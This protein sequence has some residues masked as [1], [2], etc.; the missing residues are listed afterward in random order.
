MPS[1][2]VPL[3]SAAWL[4]AH[5]DDSHVRILEVDY[6]PQGTYN[7]AHLPGALLV[8]WR[9]DLNHPVIRDVLTKE[10]LERLLGAAGVRPG[11]TL[12]VYGDLNNWFGAFAYWTVRYYGFEDVRLLDGGRRGWS[13]AAGPWTRDVPEFPPTMCRVSS[14]DARVRAF[15]PDVQ[16]ARMRRETVL[17]DVR[18]PAEFTGELVAPPEFPNENAQ[19]GGHIPG[20]VNVPW[21]QAVAPS[22]RLK[23]QMELRLLY[24]QAGV[25]PDR[26]VI[27]YCRIG[28]RSAFT[29]FVLKELLGYPNVRNYDGSWTEWGNLVGAPIE[30]VEPPVAGLSSV[31]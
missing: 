8:D 17:V 31:V 24:E 11:Q 21:W 13:D 3:A 26:E 20:A 23:S 15:L 27:T 5:L 30:R 10:R 12:V 25:T 7:L 6:D 9:R 28:E 19:R 16:A 29:W 4:K 22:G 1:N 2:P 14:P 18:S